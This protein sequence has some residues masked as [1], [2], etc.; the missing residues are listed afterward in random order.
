MICWILCIPIHNSC[1]INTIVLMLNHIEL[2]SW[3]YFH[4]VGNVTNM[5]VYIALSPCTKNTFQFDIKIITL[6]PF[7]FNPFPFSFTDQFISIQWYF[8]YV[9]TMR[10]LYVA[11]ISTTNC[12]PCFKICSSL[13]FPK[14]CLVRTIV[15]SKA[16]YKIEEAYLIEYKG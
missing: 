4:Q 16:S 7:L 15:I 11:L 3:R 9:C 12:T 5:D 13:L 8:F 1:T 14:E 2:H 10:Y 6:V